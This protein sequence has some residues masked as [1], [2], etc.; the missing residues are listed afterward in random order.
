MAN[1]GHFLVARRVTLVVAL[2]VALAFL[3][4]KFW[5]DGGDQQMIFCPSVSAV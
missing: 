4:E 2:V 1:S 5:E 3:L